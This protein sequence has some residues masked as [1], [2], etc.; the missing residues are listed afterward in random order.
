MSPHVLSRFTVGALLLVCGGNAPAAAPPVPNTGNGTVQY[1]FTPGGGADAMIIA[2]IAAAR[3]QVLVQ[4]FSFTHRRIA[5]ALVSARNRGIDVA[6]IADHEQTRA[7]DSTVIR[8]ITR[9]GVPVLL[10]S[11][12]AAAHN[13]LIVIDAG[14]QDCAVV[15][16]SYNFT[17]TAEH[18]NAENAVILRGNPP[19]CE[20]FR[21][22]WLHHKAHSVPHQR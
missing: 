7:N 13:K 20:A 8:G 14:D 19:L 18:R 16:G 2:A 4:A 6:V 15:T 1:A 9:S 3:R 21:N 11:L 22:N 5:E 12:H 17:Y 10:D